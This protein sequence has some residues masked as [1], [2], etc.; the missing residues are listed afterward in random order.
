MKF[1]T[2]QIIGEAIQ[3]DGK[4]TKD[5]TDFILNAGW[6]CYL[7]KRMDTPIFIK[8]SNGI[9]EVLRNDWVMKDGNGI[10]SLS[11]EIVE[12]FFDST[13]DEIVIK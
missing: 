4:N 3:W 11:P 12:N 13:F 5:V 2:K 8:S 9:K 6:E 7:E 1:K 10:Y